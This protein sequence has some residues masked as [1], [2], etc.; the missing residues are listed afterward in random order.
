MGDCLTGVLNSMI[1]LHQKNLNHA[2]AFA[3]GL[4]SYAA[5]VLFEERKHLGLLPS[6]VIVKMHKIINELFY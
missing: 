5:D 4:H 6:D 1:S 3:V 2:I